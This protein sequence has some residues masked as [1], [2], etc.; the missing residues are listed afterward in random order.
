M[1]SGYNINY[2]RQKP[3]E[4][5][6]LSLSCEQ[7]ASLKKETLSL[8]NEF[9]SV[10]ATYERLFSKVI[11]HSK[12]DSSFL[13]SEFLTIAYSLRHYVLTAANPLIIKEKHRLYVLTST[14]TA[15]SISEKRLL[16]DSEHRSLMMNEFSSHY[17]LEVFIKEFYKEVS[18]LHR[19]KKD[20]NTLKKSQSFV[21]KYD[22][23]DVEW[24]ARRGI[25]N[26]DLHCYTE[27]LND[28]KKYVFLTD[29]KNCSTSVKSALMELQGLKALD[30]LDAVNAKH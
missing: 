20:F 3:E 10:N 12:E 22:P 18:E 21:I 27:A 15:F 26:K 1:K 25:T 28:L 4:V 13:W 9:E 2:I 5:L 24:L 23:R 14:Q 19:N 8:F 29:G 30:T 6:S 7:W 16:T 11:E 17:S